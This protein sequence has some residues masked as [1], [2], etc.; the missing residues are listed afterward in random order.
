MK[1]RLAYLF[2][3]ITVIGLLRYFG[4]VEHDNNAGIFLFPGLI[5][6]ALF[7]SCRKDSK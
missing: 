6:I 4:G 1:K 7:I 3:A 5:A 2:L